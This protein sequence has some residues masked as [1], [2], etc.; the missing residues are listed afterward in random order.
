MGYRHVS[1]MG[2]VL[3]RSIRD[4][5]LGCAVHGQGL[6]RYKRD[7]QGKRIAHLDGH[8]VAGIVAGC[9]RRG[10]LAP[11]VGQVAVTTILL[12]LIPGKLRVRT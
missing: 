3:L 9:D 7:C 6:G 12:V 10:A 5:H 4:H 1:F 8:Q 11:V 2:A